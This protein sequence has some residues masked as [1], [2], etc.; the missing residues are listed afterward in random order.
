MLCLGFV[1]STYYGE[2]LLIELAF[3]KDSNLIRLFTR[4]DGT[5]CF[6]I[7]GFTGLIRTDFFN[8][9]ICSQVDYARQKGEGG[10][11]EAKQISPEAF[12]LHL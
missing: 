12:C 2:F 10:G 5:L 1:Y 3:S 9:L 7:D 6:K 8:G 11:C 4:L